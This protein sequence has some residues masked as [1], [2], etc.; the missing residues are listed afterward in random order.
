MFWLECFK[1]LFQKI[2]ILK[3]KKNIS[4][5]SVKKNI[6]PE[7]HKFLKQIKKNNTKAALNCQDRSRKESQEK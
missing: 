3:G 7:K 2:H 4:F 1:I 6:C 5:I